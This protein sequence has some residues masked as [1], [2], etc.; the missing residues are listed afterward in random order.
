M[1][2]AVTHLVLSPVV[3]G[4]TLLHAAGAYAGPIVFNQ[5]SVSPGPYVAWP[6]ARDASGAGFR[7]RDNFSLSRPTRIDG[8][9]WQGFSLDSI[10]PENNPPVPDTTSWEISFWSDAGGQ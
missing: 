6:S 10:P 3:V 2:S 5:P 7:S 4:F 9:N 1:R 8:V